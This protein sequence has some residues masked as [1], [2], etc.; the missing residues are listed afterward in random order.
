MLYT[1]RAVTGGGGSGSVCIF[2]LIDLINR[3]G[4]RIIAVEVGLADLSVDWGR[5]AERQSTSIT[6]R[7]SCRH[8]VH[9]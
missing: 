9:E 8:L 3:V 7:E 1:T 2:R 6:R 5:D 4:L